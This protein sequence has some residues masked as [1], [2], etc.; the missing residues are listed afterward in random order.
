MGAGDE[1]TSLRT[2]FLLSVETLVHESEGRSLGISDS[3]YRDD[4]DAVEVI[5]IPF[6]DHRRV[7]AVRGEECAGCGFDILVLPGNKDA[8][9]AVPRLFEHGSQSIRI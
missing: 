7:G 3:G 5:G 9:V 6:R 8:R 4:I 2:G 1:A